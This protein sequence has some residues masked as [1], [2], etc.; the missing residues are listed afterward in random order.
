MDNQID[1]RFLARPNGQLIDHLISVGVISKKLAGEYSEVIW[2]AS[3]LHDLGKATD[4]WQKYLIRNVQ[5]WLDYKCGKRQKP[6]KDTIP[7]AVHGAVILLERELKGKKYEFISFLIAS[8][9][10][11]HHGSL[12]FVNDKDGEKN[13]ST[14]TECKSNTSGYVLALPPIK[15]NHYPVKEKKDLFNNWL[16]LKYMFS[17][18]VDADR[19][20]A[21]RT[22]ENGHSNGVNNTVNYN[23]SHLDLSQSGKIVFKPHFKLP[24]DLIDD[25]IKRDFREVLLNA[26]WTNLNTI[27]APCGLGKTIASLA[28][29]CQIA[30]AEG[31]SRIIYVAALKTILEQTA[32]VYSGCLPGQSILE[33]HSDYEPKLKVKDTEEQKEEE[34]KEYEYN[35]Q[36]WNSEVIV[37]TMVQ[38]VDSLL[39]PHCNKNRKIH[40]LDNSVV[41][42]DEVQTLPEHLLIYV[43][44]CIDFLSKHHNVTFI[45]MSA[46][47]PHF[48]NLNYLRI[49]KMAFNELVPA[50]KITEYYKTRELATVVN[51][52]QETDI[53]KIACEYDQPKLVIVNTTQQ[54]QDFY[55]IM[56]EKQPGQWVHL[57]SRMCPDHR[58]AV[59]K[60]IRENDGIN[61]ISTQVVEAG[62]D[63]SRHVVISQLAPLD[64]LIQRMGRCNRYGI[65]P[66]GIFV[67]VG[68]L[69]PHPYS[70]LR[71][72]R[73]E[74]ILI[75]RDIIKEQCDVVREYFQDI[76]YLPPD[77]KSNEAELNKKSPLA[78]GRAM[79]QK[80]I[81]RMTVLYF[82]SS[83]GK[84][85][86]IKQADFSWLNDNDYRS[87]PKD[88]KNTVLCLGYGGF[89]V[90]MTKEK[91]MALNPKDKTDRRNL[92]SLSK[93][94][95]TVP[96]DAKDIIY[97]DN[98]LC[99]WDGEYD[100]DCGVIW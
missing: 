87:I 8:A 61:I 66:D 75:S 44:L 54:A 14:I 63:I 91:L 43:L 17:V 34:L 26:T 56:S 6:K 90:A 95:A 51:R 4:T 58:R 41:I 5:A 13:R 50:D 59:I 33:N 78:Q 96:N 57:S 53:V 31:K 16:L 92:K 1:R 36:T 10:K 72:D 73:T 81:D 55:R 2:L 23:R 11:S 21:M 25:P 47:Q 71:L 86:D 82:L 45:L 9:I 77:S 27:T 83:E 52:T 15:S 85:P 67:V 80:L 19:E 35:C 69:K 84:L 74:S 89:P 76:Y 99:I 40:N 60:M 64:S 93:Y 48:K 3:V 18:M 98:G 68:C 97:L 49:N 32:G 12:K 62:V 94:Q 46:T 22:T 88:N 79:V 42:L 38:F 100:Q 39:S 29:A 7:H 30:N 65:G 20:D 70:Q 28:K 37:T 24:D